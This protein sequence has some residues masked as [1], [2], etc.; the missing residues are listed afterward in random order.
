MEKFLNSAMPS[1]KIAVFIY[2]PQLRVIFTFIPKIDCSTPFVILGLQQAFE[3]SLLVFTFCFRER[4]VNST[5]LGDL[6]TTVRLLQPDSIYN[7]RV[8]AYNKNGPGLS[9][10]PIQTR[11]KAECKTFFSADVDRAN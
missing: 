8:I 6:R 4:V 10:A 3:K 11:T 2:F 9:S 5:R 1:G 7:F